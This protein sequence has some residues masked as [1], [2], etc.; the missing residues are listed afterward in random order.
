[1]LAGAWMA[2]ELVFRVRM[3]VSVVCR[4]DEVCEAVGGFGT[5]PWQQMLVGVNRE[6]RVRVPESL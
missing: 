1:M 6:R 3:A 4:F 2:G 5:H